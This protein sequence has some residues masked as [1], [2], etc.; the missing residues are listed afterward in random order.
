MERL[1]CQS[2]NDC[3][4]L[5]QAMAEGWKLREDDCLVFRGEWQAYPQIRTSL[6]R[7]NTD[8]QAFLKVLVNNLSIHLLDKY[9]SPVVE[10]R[11]DGPF[12]KG[13]WLG[14]LH[15]AERYL[16]NPS[17]LWVHW[18]I[19]AL[20]QHYGW[21]THWLDVTFDPRVALFFASLNYKAGCLALEGRGYLHVWSLAALSA[22]GSYFDTPVVGLRPISG[23]LADV[24]GVVA[25]RPGAQHAAAMRIPSGQVAIDLHLLES[26][27]ALIEFERSDAASVCDPVTTYF[28]P[29]PLSVEL[30]TFESQY[31]DW[32]L[33]VADSESEPFTNA[34]RQWRA[35]KSAL[36]A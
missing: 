34:L 9:V 31:A 27:I 10:T 13:K 16:A 23:L 4:K 36:P 28:P 35:A 3:L 19:Q 33:Q 24:C 8:E 5:L 6:S 15:I 7:R 29:D 11:P 32:Y 30:D 14:D 25:V 2:A 17:F 1:A 21:P 12:Y 18:Q 20:L 22:H 26:R